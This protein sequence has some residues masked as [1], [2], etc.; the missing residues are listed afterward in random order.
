M[1]RAA[2]SVGLLLAL[3][4]GGA[5]AHKGATGIVKQRMDAMK[6]MAD[7]TKAVKAELGKGA[8][9]DAAVVIFHAGAIETHAGQ[10][11]VALYPKGSDGHPSEAKPKIWSEPAAFATAAET[12]K[13]RAQA[14]A[15]AAK[16]GTPPN[17]EFKALLQACAACH[18]SFRVKRNK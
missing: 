3:A 10:D 16:S 8:G 6:S 5:A 17:A 9:Y 18:K 13:L 1:I 14:L 2:I 15:A 11:L 4:A 7:A 12:L